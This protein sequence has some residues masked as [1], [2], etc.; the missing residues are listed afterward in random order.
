MPED[1]YRLLVANA[2]D[3][4]IF[5]ADT[6][7]VIQTWSPGAER[8]FGYTESE[9]QGQSCD[10][11]FV[12][13]DRDAG[14]PDL[15]RSLALRA[16]RAENERWHLRKDGSRFWGAGEMVPLRTSAHGHVGF[17]KITRDFTR[18]RELETAHLET[19]R[20]EGIGLFAGGLA[21][22]FNNLLTASLGNL[23]LLLQRAEL[24]SNREARELVASAVQAGLRMAELTHQILTFAGKARRR[25]QPIDLYRKVHEALEAVGHE[26]PRNIA[27]V[28]A[29]P[30]PSPLVAG[31]ATLLRQLMTSL[32]VNAVE[33][34][35][36]RE[37]DGTITVTGEVC[38]LATDQLR[39]A[40]AGFD[41]LPGRYVRL[42]VTDTGPGL[43]PEAQARLFD[44]FYSTKFQGRGLGLAAALGIVRMHG[45]AIT[46]RSA[47][48]AGTTFEVLLPVDGEAESR[49]NEGARMA[50][51]VDDEELVRS[52]T[53]RILEA[54]GFTV[55]QGEN[56]EQAVH[57]ARRLGSRI[58]LV[59][60]DLAMPEPDGAMTLPILRTLLGRAS[61]IVMTE[62]GASEPKGRLDHA[63]LT[64]LQKPFT[65]AQLT[66]AIET[67]LA[68]RAGGSSATAGPPSGS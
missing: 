45:G 67:A 22:L 36:Q 62:V 14:V 3:Y 59:L 39:H 44:P 34:M 32:V 33:A 23:D 54:E 12:L 37:V 28:V 13:E 42:T 60:L 53:S 56:G 1:P 30:E 46:A 52:L 58:E 47:P 61:I 6:D 50:L 16:G 2:A 9:I 4:A 20:M 15:E 7:G 49:P 29:L 51:V 64:S 38:P 31:D 40:Y 55:V 57:I 10:M 25:L 48:G 21:H 63:G 35:S 68:V 41:L 5:T 11:L 19:Q 26:I 27:L 8:I 43:S 65:Y 17:G 24:R 18:R 66:A